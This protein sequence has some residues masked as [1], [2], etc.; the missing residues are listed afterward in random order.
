MDHRLE[1]MDNPG[2]MMSRLLQVAMSQPR[3]PV[4]CAVPRETAMLPIPGGVSRFPSR[5]QLGVNRPTSPTP[6]DASEIAR[7]L[8][9]AENPVVFT[10]RSGDDH[11]A[12]EE[13]VRLAELLALPIS[14]SAGSY[15]LNFPMTHYCYGTGLRSKDAD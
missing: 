12:V 15:R 13:L 11:A 8:V 3:G 5:D 6:E 4:Y 14:E 1:H 2:F 7:W 9:K 10:G